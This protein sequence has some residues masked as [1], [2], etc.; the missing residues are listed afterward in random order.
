MGKELS[1]DVWVERAIERA[2]NAVLRL[3]A[4]Q[5]TTGPTGDV[6]RYACDQLFTASE[7]LR[8]AGFACGVGDV[9]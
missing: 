8:D 4:A 5:Y 1:A 6:L 9:R 3:R 7:H 2:E